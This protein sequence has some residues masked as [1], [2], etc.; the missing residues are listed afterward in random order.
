MRGSQLTGAL[1]ALILAIGALVL[2][3][4]HRFP[5]P[6]PLP[7]PP[8]DVPRV[9]V[10]LGDSTVSGEGAGDYDPSTDGER[11]NWCHRSPHAFIHQLNVSG[12]DKTINLAC[13]G[14]DTAQVGLGSAVQHTETSQ[15]RRLAAIAATNR[16]VAVVVAVGA[17]DDPSFADT[18]N[19]CIDAW[20]N[21]NG[22]ACHGTLEREWPRRVEAMV[23][24]V[25][26]TLRDIKGVL[27]AIGYQE[28]DYSLVLQ[29][30]AAPIGPNVAVGLQ[31]LSGC[32]FRT[33]DLTWVQDVAM[34][35]LTSGLRRAAADS[36]ARFLDLSRSG[37]GREACSAGADP[38]KEWFQRLVVQWNDL[39]DE[40]RATHAVQESF[41]PN[42]AGHA[43][44]GRCL[45]EFLYTADRAAACLPGAD[46]ALHPAP[47]TGLP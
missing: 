35:E 13:S 45:G 37:T 29:S 36:G 6:T 47:S 39:R 17:N 34:P 44:F 9:V 33:A 11:N 3:G 18:L 41:H 32:P 42:A 10:A 31:D 28:S 43:Q 8:Q 46:G 27:A 40:A 7:G 12:V 24:K 25:V 21:R 5:A 20:F 1:F 38:A 15:T 19:G 2:V 26:E 30:Y 4:D 22:P 16:V 23:P 14:A